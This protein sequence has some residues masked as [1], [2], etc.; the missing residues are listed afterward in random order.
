MEWGILVAAVSV[1]GSLAL[2]L[3]DVVNTPG[4]TDR[5][6]R[7]PIHKLAGRHLTTK[8]RKVA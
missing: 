1:F 8:L 3:S 7:R 2:A 4:P 5:T 6:I